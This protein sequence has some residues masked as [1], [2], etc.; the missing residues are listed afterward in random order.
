[1]TKFHARREIFTSHYL[2][3][4]NESSY[5][6][7]RACVK[8]SNKSF[9]QS[10][11][12]WSLN[13]RQSWNLTSNRTLTNKAVF[14]ITFCL[15]PNLQIIV[16]FFPFSCNGRSGERDSLYESFNTLLRYILLH[17]ENIAHEM[18][19]RSSSPHSAVTALIVQTSSNLFHNLLKKNRDANFNLSLNPY[20]NL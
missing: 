7:L 1:M 9:F 11:S 14:S 6:I 13:Y 8:I 15:N 20:G 17:R 16:F 4:K 5:K 19:M 3:K 12:S 10:A 18:E 2:F